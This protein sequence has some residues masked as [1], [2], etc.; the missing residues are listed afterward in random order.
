MEEPPIQLL[1]RKGHFLHGAQIHKCEAFAAILDFVDVKRVEVLQ[2]AP[3]FLLRDVQREIADIH[4]RL[5]L[6]ESW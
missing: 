2:K 3:N 6:P 5:S 1:D 4:L